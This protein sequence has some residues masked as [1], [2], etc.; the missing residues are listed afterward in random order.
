MSSKPSREFVL[1]ALFGA[2]GFAVA[3]LAPIHILLQGIVYPYERVVVAALRY[4]NLRQ[5][6]SQPIAKL[7]LL[8]LFGGAFFHAAHRVRYAIFDLG[9]KRGR[10]L[11]AIILYGGAVAGSATAAWV[12]LRA[13]GP[14]VATSPA[15][16]REE[17]RAWHENAVVADAHA[18]PLSWNRDLLHGSE[19]AEIDLP[20]LQ[21]GGVDIQSFTVATRGMPMVDLFG[22]YARWVN[23]WPR[24]AARDEVSRAWFEIEALEKLERSAP[25]RFAIARTAGDFRR[26]LASGHTVGVLGLE[27]VHA[28]G[29]DLSN[30][31]A[32]YRRGVRFVGIA[33]LGNNEYG[34]SSFA[35]SPERGLSEK[36]REVVREIERLGMIFDLS[37]DSDTTFDDI[38]SMTKGPLFISHTC[39]D[40]LNPHWRNHTDEQA[41][42]I[43]ERGGIVSVM[44]ATNF[45]G[46]EDLG[47]LV[48][49]IEHFAT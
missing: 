38:L 8:V 19:R 20:K 47:R 15:A 10:L 24:E 26:H 13:P 9:I 27:G 30:L 17:V 28:V 6:I 12:L 34:G 45:L 4:E 32:F 46:G 11:V 23:G 5:L 16:V 49:H 3:L 43:A 29:G 31:E 33:H 14:A 36:G 25:D 2:G 39:S 37:H 1:W 22:P 35:L 44:F 40:A 7:Y 48:E 42:R 18:D 41:R 21:Q